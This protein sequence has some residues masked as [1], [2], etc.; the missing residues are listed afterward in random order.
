MR[1]PFSFQQFR[2]RYC[3]C[4]QEM[5]TPH[6]DKQVSNFPSDITAG[7]RESDHVGLTANLLCGPFLYFVAVLG[8][9]YPWLVHVAFWL[10]YHCSLCVLVGSDSSCCLTFSN[11]F[12]I[13]FISSFFAAAF[14]LANSCAN[15]AIFCLQ[16]FNP[17]GSVKWV[18][19]LTHAMI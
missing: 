14:F 7:I 18:Q 17:T 1:T 4:Q 15:C 16:Y 11:N 13:L 19:F 5:K 2:R 8:P 12:S 9:C 6:K 10:L 3:V